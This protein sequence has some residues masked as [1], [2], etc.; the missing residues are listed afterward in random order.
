MAR[1][2]FALG[3]AAALLLAVGVFVGVQS[4][5]PRTA[6][7]APKA[8]A[9]PFRAGYVS[10]SELMKDYDKWQGSA[11]HMEEKRQRATKE[12]VRMRDLIDRGNNGGLSTN[13][14]SGRGDMVYLVPPEPK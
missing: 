2:S 6:D 10:M 9:K 7:A 1:R 14:R 8:E 12:L 5:Q 3:F 13:Q 4:S 11:K